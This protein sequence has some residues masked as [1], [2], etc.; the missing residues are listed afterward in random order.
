MT[1]FSRKCIV[2]DM[3]S[4]SPRLCTAYAQLVNK[5]A[6]ASH[7]PCTSYPSKNVQGVA[8]DALSF[9]KAESCGCGLVLAQCGAVCLAGCNW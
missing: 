7:G 6:M 5:S 9:G 2:S 1:F 8:C 3:I 4:F